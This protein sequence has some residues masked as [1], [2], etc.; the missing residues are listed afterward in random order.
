MPALVCESCKTMRSDPEDSFEKADGIHID[1]QE[2]SR[3]E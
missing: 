1:Q 2:L 3:V